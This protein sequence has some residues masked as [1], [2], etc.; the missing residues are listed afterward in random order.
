MKSTDWKT[1]FELIG[2][3]AIVASLIFVG[4]QLKQSHEIALAAQYH[5]RAALSIENFN[6]EMESGD[7]AFWGRRGQWVAGDEQSIEDRGRE[8]LRSIKYL[9]IVDNHYYQYQAGFLEEEM[10][11]SQLTGLKGQLKINAR[12]RAT[13]RNR[14]NLLSPTFLNLANGLLDDAEP[15][16][17][18][19]K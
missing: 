8:V 18:G 1:T 15:S 14:I 5:A 16:V 11:Q 7:L 9:L 13:V 3:G 12:L 19:E 4:L 2:V 17:I 10:W 6:A